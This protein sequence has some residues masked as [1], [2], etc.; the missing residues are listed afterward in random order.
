[1]Q[2]PYTLQNTLDP[3]RFDKQNKK[4]K[5]T[6]KEE[7]QRLTSGLAKLGLK[8]LPEFL[9]C[10]LTVGYNPNCVQLNPNCAK[11]PGRYATPEAEVRLRK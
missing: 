11:P 5:E 2:V 9:L 3:I 1:V 6:A 8:L 10:P 7:C 4:R